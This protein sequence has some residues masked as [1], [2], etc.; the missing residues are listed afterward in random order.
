MGFRRVPA[1]SMRGCTFAPAA[2]EPGT[3][4]T[5]PPPA[6]PGAGAISA[7]LWMRQEAGFL[8]QCRIPLAQEGARAG[9]G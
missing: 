6:L 1:V 5:G 9:L 3:G 2:S 4:R 8:G 7:C